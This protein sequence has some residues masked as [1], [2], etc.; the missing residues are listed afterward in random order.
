[1]IIALL[2]RRFWLW[3]N[4]IIS[5]IAIILVLPIIIFIMIDLSLKNILT[6]S[7]TGIPFDRWVFPGL[8]YIVASFSMIPS[9][10]R[11]FFDLRIHNKVLVN[12]ALAPFSKNTI[13]FSYI[14]VAGLEAIFFSF[15]ATL[16]YLGFMPLP[17]TILQIIFMAFCLILYL[18][19]LGNFILSIS[20]I[21]NSINNF[22]LIILMV[23]L[24]IVFGNGFIIEFGFFPNIIGFILEWQPLAIPYKTFQLYL[25]NGIIEFTYIG[26]ILILSWIWILFNSFILKRKLG[27]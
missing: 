16:I 19:I 10:F 8:I 23:T 7:L 13:I 14:I 21:I 12:V 25:T 15:I 1:M 4:N 2:K 27:Q 22:I 9:I 17:L 18:N 20:L 6:R 11:D 26:F 5:T 3:Q 24:F